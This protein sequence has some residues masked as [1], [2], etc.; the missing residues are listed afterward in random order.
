MIAL[1]RTEVGSS[2]GLL[3]R[4]MELTTPTLRF[5]L[6]ENELSETLA[7]VARLSF[8]EVSLLNVILETEHMT[9]V[10]QLVE[11]HRDYRKAI[12]EWGFD[13]VL[14]YADEGEATVLGHLRRAIEFDRHA[15]ERDE[16]AA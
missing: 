1:G 9:Q 5:I 7:K 4:R 11:N 16:P 3:S 13:K 10:R 14:P 6:K 12:S 8:P 2:E 15:R